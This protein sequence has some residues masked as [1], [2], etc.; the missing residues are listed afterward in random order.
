[1]IVAIIQNEVVKNTILVET[2]EIAQGLFPEATIKELASGFGI[3]DMYKNDSFIKTLS[4]NDNGY[5]SPEQQRITALES[6]IEELTLAVLQ[7]G[8]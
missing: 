2:L 6:E 4:N 3:G 1:M 5:E 8:Q 7:G